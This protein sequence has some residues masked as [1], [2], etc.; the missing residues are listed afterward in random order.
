MYFRSPTSSR[1][2][3][4]WSTAT[5]N[6]ATDPTIHRLGSGFYQ[7]VVHVRGRFF[8]G[9]ANEPALAKARAETLAAEARNMNLGSTYEQ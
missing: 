5:S 8:R 3:R 1:K 9:L 6:K 4:R 2:I 7:A